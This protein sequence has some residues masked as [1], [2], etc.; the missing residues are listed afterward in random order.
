MISLWQ[1]HPFREGNTRTVIIF[2]CKYLEANGIKLNN[3]VFKED[4]IYV[5]KALVAASFEDEEIDVY[6]NKSYILEIIQDSLES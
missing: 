3:D 4:A 2:I 1:V 5:R 6:A